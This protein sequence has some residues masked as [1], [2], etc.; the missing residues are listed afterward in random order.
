M[1]QA[2]HVQPVPSDPDARWAQVD[3]YF[4]GLVREDPDGTAT[5]ERA[6]EAGLPDIAVAPNQGKLLQLLAS[7]VGARRVLEIG[8][9]GGYSTLW[10]ARALPSDGSLVSLELDPKHAEV[11]R[12]SLTQAGVGDL[13]EVVVG[14]AVDS[15]GALVAAATEP[16][17][18][19]FIDADKQQLARYVEL[20]LALSRPG[21]AIVVDNVVR[22]GAVIDPEHPDDRVQGVRRMVE[23]LTDHPR[24]EATVLQTVGSKGYDGFALLRVLP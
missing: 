15:L 14:P 17:D 3:S 16:F 8:T 23:L 13:V 24:V 18:F 10:L 4:G 12:A 22:D 11:A 5:R 19:I 6:A 1:A 21:T 2:P 7:L 9:L 20:S